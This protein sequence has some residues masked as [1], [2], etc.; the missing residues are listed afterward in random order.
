MLDAWSY[1]SG[2]SR[3]GYEGRFADDETGIHFTY[4]IEAHV[5]HAYAKKLTPETMVL[6]LSKDAILGR[7]SDALLLG[8][9]FLSMALAFTPCFFLIL[10]FGFYPRKSGMV[11]DWVEYI[12]SRKK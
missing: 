9:T 12:K 3:E 11:Y 1:S 5:Y 6:M 7:N 2:N 8:V 4:R 10:Q